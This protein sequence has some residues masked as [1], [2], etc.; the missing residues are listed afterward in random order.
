MSC[1]LGCL[2]VSWRDRLLWPSVIYLCMY[3]VFDISK[4]SLSVYV[5]SLLGP[6]LQTVIFPRAESLDMEELNMMVSGHVLRR[7]KGELG[8][9]W[10]QS[11]W[12]SKWLVETHHIQL[13]P[14]EQQVHDVL[15]F[16]ARWVSVFVWLGLWTI[17]WLLQDWIHTGDSQQHC[18]RCPNSTSKRGSGEYSRLQQHSWERMRDAVQRLINIATYVLVYSEIEACRYLLLN[19]LSTCVVCCI[20]VASESVL[21]YFGLYLRLMV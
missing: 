15:F 7:T 20:C 2:K 9:Q 3:V 13:K 10:D 11:Y 12:S 16:V 19:L 14:S 6:H 17:K 21:Y 5:A 18:Y 1:S 8:P 4:R